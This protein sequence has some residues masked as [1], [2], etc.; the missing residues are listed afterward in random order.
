MKKS[1][2]FA[3]AAAGAL[4]SGTLSAADI[5]SF[6]GAE[7]YG[8]FA[9]GG[10]GG[11]IYHV[12]NLDDSGKGSLRDAVSQPNRI[13]VFDVSGVIRIKSMLSFK[14]NLTVLGQTAPGEGVQV[15][16]DRIS[17]SGADNLIV[18]YMRFHMGVNGTK[19][20][21]A[22]GVANG[23][24]MI[25]D[26]L[27]IFW[28][29]DE[30]FSINWDN[31]NNKPGDITI[32]NSIIGQGLQPHSAGGLIQTDQGVTLYRNLYIENSTRNNKVK[33]LNQYV[34]N[35][36]YNWG[37]AYIMGGD[38]EGNSWAELRGN[39]FVRGP[40]TGASMPFIRGNSNFSYYADDNFYDE[41]LNGVLDGHLMTQEEYDK[42][43]SKRIETLEALESAAPKKFPVIEGLMTAN[44]AIDWVGKNVG[45]SLP[46]RDEVDQ[47]VIDELLSYGTLG[48]TAGIASEAQ[49]PHK[50]TGKLFGGYLPKDSD[51]DGIP[52]AWETANGLNPNDASDAAAIASNGYANIEN[53]A[54]SLTGPH[55]YVKNPTDLKADKIDA[56]SISFTWADNSEDET[57]FVVEMS[58]DGSTYTQIGE[59]PANSTS[60]KA[61]NLEKDKTYYFRV[62][63]VK[64]EGETQ[65]LSVWS[66][67][68]K[69][70][71]VA[72]PTAPVAS[73]VKF[74]SDGATVKQLDLY[75]QWTNST[76]ELF[77]QTRY[78]VYLGTDPNN[79]DPIVYDITDTSFTPSDLTPGT[80]YWRVDSSNDIGTTEGKV[81]SFNLE[82]GGVMFY[83]DFHSTPQDFAD[84]D[85]GTIIK[86]S[87]LDMIKGSTGNPATMEIGVMTF[88]TEG[89]IVA[90]G[91][92]G[93][94][95]YGP[96]TSSD[97]G[98]SNNAV[99]FIGKNGNVSSA[100]IKISEI[101]GPWI[102]TVY[103]GNSDNKGKVKFDIADSQETLATFEM[104]K[105]KKYFKFTYTNTKEGIS[106]FIIR[107]AQSSDNKQGV[108][109]FD[110]KI[111]K[112]VTASS[113]VGSIAEDKNDMR[114][115]IEKYDNTVTVNNL[116]KDVVVEVL[117]LSGRMIERAKS[118]GGSVSFALGHGVYIIR[119]TGAKPAKIIL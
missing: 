84:S 65:L 1:F 112:Y 66:P 113:A 44:E 59:L 88:S 101:E 27:S 103:A 82:A 93:A 30:T 77:G 34:N 114:L 35:V 68:L 80:Y 87:Q 52:D 83:T 110:V 4:C 51:G 96:Y 9:T 26:H 104:A 90:F 17:F 118:L 39:Y 108:N 14:G 21:D 22:C 98:A 89:R 57:G 74:P 42:S 58:G 3:L 8:R 86:G 47:Y 63:A 111:E 10:R 109:F 67:V 62:R 37:E 102:A 60:F 16:G 23:K 94:S 95:S 99:G 50:G 28:G 7:G 69:T 45:A 64:N 79:L 61:D 24:N 25:F 97:S 33:G 43:G 55:P 6:P 31:K 5:V 46:V 15:Y 40:W 107:N 105:A 81:W 12:T 20:K 13:V 54:N 119:T 18:R 106:D 2:Y 117:D 116:A 56:N 41:N 100:F 92:L 71:T 70:L 38:S 73:N 29:R 32:Q 91:N 85:F 19:D 115:D 48:S 36:I 72:N 75:L 78:T 11:E 76:E 49:L 53:Y